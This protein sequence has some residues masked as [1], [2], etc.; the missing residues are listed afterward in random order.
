M[1]HSLMN[2]L[3]KGAH[4]AFTVDYGFQTNLEHS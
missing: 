3:Q 1:L 4:L 2:F